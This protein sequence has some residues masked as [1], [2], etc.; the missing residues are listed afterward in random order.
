MISLFAQDF[1]AKN[2][3]KDKLFV[4]SLLASK[5]INKQKH[6][7]T[8]IYIYIY[9]YMAEASFSAYLFAFLKGKN[10]IF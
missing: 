10:S 2:E 8:Y 4:S 7:H 6:T 1:R 9:I 5:S 3:A